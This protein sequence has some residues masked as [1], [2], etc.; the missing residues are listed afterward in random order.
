MQLDLL[1]FDGDILQRL[2]LKEF[3]YKKLN[4]N[5]LEANDLIEKITAGQSQRL[6]IADELE[7]DTRLFLSGLDLSFELAA[8]QKHFYTIH[9]GRKK[10]L[11]A[12]GF[13]M[14]FNEC[15]VGIAGMKPA[16][17]LA[18]KLIQDGQITVQVIDYKLDVFTQKVTQLG[19]QISPA[20]L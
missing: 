1:K 10:N 9:F 13:G 8:A 7:A 5:Y 11:I 6:E 4:I 16:M 15:C 2:D 19:G 14:I 3:L 20:A 18:K 17:E 12:I